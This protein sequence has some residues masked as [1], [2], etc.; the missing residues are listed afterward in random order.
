MTTPVTITV[1]GHAERSVAPNRCV[2]RLSVEFDGSTRAEAADAATASVTALTESIRTCESELVR[3]SID[4]VQHSRHRPYHP[5]GETLPWIYRSTA[6]GSAVFRDLAAVA[7]FVDR[8]AAIDGVT[9]AHLEWTLTRTKHAKTV[10]RVRDLAVRDAVAK[11]R[12]YARSL[13]F[14]HVTVVALADPGLLDGTR[15]DAGMP[16]MRTMA[17][18]ARGGDLPTIELTP[19]K[20][21]ITAEVEARFEAQ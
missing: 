12:G 20:L 1:T 8:V 15:P 19:E 17:A 7:G 14:E 18:S 3:W 2:V 9:V 11:A 21:R 6:T 16:V 4:Q 5:E 10:A 13:G